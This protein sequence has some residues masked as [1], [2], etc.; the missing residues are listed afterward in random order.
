L[1]KFA[2]IQAK[3]KSNNNP[4]GSYGLPIIGETLAFVFDKNYVSK[5][6]QQ[7]GSIFKTSLIGKPTAVMIGAEAAEF[8]L[9][10]H[11]KHFS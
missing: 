4:L 3:M 1:I 5:R 7:Y 6:Y 10:T 2:S 9:S 11:T 8:I